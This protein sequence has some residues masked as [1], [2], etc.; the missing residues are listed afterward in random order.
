MEQR[1]RRLNRISFTQYAMTD[2]ERRN[3]FT[4]TL[5]ATA[6]AT[7][8]GRRY[9][10]RG[11]RRRRGRVDGG[12]DDE[13]RVRV[14]EACKARTFTI[15]LFSYY[16]RRCTVD[17]GARWRPTTDRQRVTQGATNELAR[18]RQ[19]FLHG[20]ERRYSR[21]DYSTGAPFIL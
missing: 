20:S 11:V 15:F 4:L 21:F 14:V 18:R 16:Y 10:F 17:V 2:R 19:Y 13:R 6:T 12:H 8:T 5:T 7:A 9:P 3:H 1:G